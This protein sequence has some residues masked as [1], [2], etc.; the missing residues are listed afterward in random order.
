MDEVLGMLPLKPEITELKTFEREGVGLSVH[1][2]L[3]SAETFEREEEE[4]ERPEHEKSWE[5]RLRWATPETAE[6][7]QKLINRVETDLPGV[8][9]VPRYRY[10]CLYKGQGRSLESLFAVLMIKKKGVSVRIKVDPF[11]KLETK[12]VYPLLFFQHSYSLL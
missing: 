1:A 10:F 2:H 12:T 3:V 4:K 11:N 8:S 9:G 5:A 7:I 6:I